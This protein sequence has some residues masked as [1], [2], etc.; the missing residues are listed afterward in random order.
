[1]KQG[2]VVQDEMST[3]IQAKSGNAAFQIGNYIWLALLWYEF[4]SNNWLPTPT[5]GSPEI[6]LIGMMGQIAV[7]FV[8]SYING[9]KVQ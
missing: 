8:Y 6:V 1:M 4:L 3:I 5:I 7:Y 9:K 2:F